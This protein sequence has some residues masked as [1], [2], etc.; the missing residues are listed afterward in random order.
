MHALLE[1]YHYLSLKYNLLET[2]AVKHALQDIQ[3]EFSHQKANLDNLKNFV[4]QY[5][6]EGPQKEEIKQQ[7]DKEF[8]AENYKSKTGTR[9]KVPS[10]GEQPDSR[11]EA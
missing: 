10:H 4:E 7:F 2:T 8:L 11:S 3:A 9:W 6:K 5:R 1:K